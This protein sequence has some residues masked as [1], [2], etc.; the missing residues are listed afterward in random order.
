MSVFSASTVRSPRER[1]VASR[2]VLLRTF[3][4]DGVGVDTP[5]WFRVDGDVLVFRTK[6]GP[7]TR[8]LANRAD[9]EFRLCDY[10]GRIVA[11]GPVMYGRATILDGA[12]ADAADRALRRRYGWFQWKIVPLI[13]IPGVT[14]VFS[15]LSWRDKIRLASTGG[16]WPEA[17]LVRVELG[18]TSNDSGSQ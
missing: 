13:A 3:R 6:R 4:R 15:V 7:K 10:R 9:V 18:P 12:A 17:A 14:S 16:T 11:D 1:V 2:Y 8:R 5:I